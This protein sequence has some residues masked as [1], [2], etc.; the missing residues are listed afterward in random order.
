[1]KYRDHRGG[2]K[3][4]M[5]TVL[6][7]GLFSE[8]EAHL[9]NLNSKKVV[10]I[11]F[12]YVGFDVRIGWDTYYVLQRL[13]GQRNCTVAGMSDGTLSEKPEPD[14]ESI[15]TITIKNQWFD[16]GLEDETK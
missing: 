15:V 1:M 13:E 6:E 12:E 10:E 8:L 14:P 2:L 4:S 9:K 7:F 11:K 3:E 16:K 5:D